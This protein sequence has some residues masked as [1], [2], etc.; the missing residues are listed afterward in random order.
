MGSEKPQITPS[1]NEQQVSKPIERQFTQSQV[2]E[3][4]RERIKRTQNSLLN[5]YGVQSRDELDGMIGKAQSYQIIKEKYEEQGYQLSRTSIV[6]WRLWIT[7][8]TLK[9]KAILWLTLRAKE[10]SLVKKH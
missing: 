6:N 1:G 4:M 5:R 2:N 9:E 7:T 3:I 8:S 10:E